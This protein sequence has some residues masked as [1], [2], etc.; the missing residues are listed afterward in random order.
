MDEREDN[1]EKRRAAET[2]RLVFLSL[3][4]PWDAYLRV[5]VLSRPPGKIRYGPAGDGLTIVMI[6]SIGLEI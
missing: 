3:L 6:K 4:L 2:A 5:H 1:D